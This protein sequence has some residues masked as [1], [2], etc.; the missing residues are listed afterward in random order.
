MSV[1]GAEIRLR[2]E[3]LLRAG[4]ANRTSDEEVEDA[5]SAG[6]GYAL[7]LDAERVRMER[8]ITELAAQAE[9]PEAATELRRLW[10]R[11]RTLDNELGELRA[12]LGELRDAQ[13]AESESR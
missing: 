10:L 5:L 12:K 13:L 3:M 7:S 9:E 6:Y 11:H 2:I 8:R 4:P 1:N